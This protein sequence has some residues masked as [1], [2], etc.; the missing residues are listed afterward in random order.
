M[1]DY[2]VEAGADEGA[3]DNVRYFLP[4]RMTYIYNYI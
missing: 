2:L 3:I 4:I 1:F